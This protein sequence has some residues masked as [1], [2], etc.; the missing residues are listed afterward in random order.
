MDDEG[1]I[2]YKLQHDVRALPDFLDIRELE[3]CRRQLIEAKLIGQ[4]PER[5][6][7]LGFGNLSQRL[8]GSEQFVVTGS[9][10]GGKAQ[11]DIQGYALV[12]DYALSENRLTSYG[13]VKP[14]SESTT[15]AFLYRLDPAICAVVHVHS[16]E[17]WRHA[18][19]LNLPTT[20]QSAAYGSPELLTAITRLWNSGLLIKQ[21]IFVMLGHEDGVIAFGK[22][23]EAAT[24][25]VLDTCHLTGKL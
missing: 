13:L 19:D 22:T 25:R 6:G 14:S 24:K 15:H 8:P 9:Q 1:V 3:S 5:Y 11:L 17:I 23:C 16:A 12:T 4:D 2:K 10:T 18:K 21:Q 20:A 7:G